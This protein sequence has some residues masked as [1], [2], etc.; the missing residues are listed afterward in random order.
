MPRFSSREFLSFA[1]HWVNTSLLN[2]AGCTCN[3]YRRY[4]FS[5][6]LLWVFCTPTTISCECI[7]NCLNSSLLKCHASS[8]KYLMLK[9]SYQNAFWETC[10]FSHW[11]KMSWL[12]YCS[13]NIS[14]LHGEIYEPNKWI[15]ITYKRKL[16]NS[17][18]GCQRSWGS[19]TL[20]AH[21]TYV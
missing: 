13:S 6:I 9:R 19:S 7:N 3:F 16:S 20:A 18:T 4:V 1:I 14:N 10:H 17:L 8:S 11:L 2:C 5:V 21:Y 15:Q 12:V